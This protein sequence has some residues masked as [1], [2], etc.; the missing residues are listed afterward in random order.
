MADLAS[1]DNSLMNITFGQSGQF[2]SRHYRDQFPA[3]FQGHGIPAPFSESAEAN[4]RTHHLVLA[5]TS[6]IAALR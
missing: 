6:G 2:S 4:T 1:W 5:P 3:W